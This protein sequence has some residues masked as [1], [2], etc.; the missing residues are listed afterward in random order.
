MIF[1][2]K[3]FESFG[4]ITQKLWQK[5]KWKSRVWQNAINSTGVSCIHPRPPQA[6]ENQQ[7]DANSPFFK[8]WEWGEEGITTSILWV[9][10]TQISSIYHPQQISLQIYWFGNGK[11]AFSIRSPRKFE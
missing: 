7:E 10:L 9:G 8:D 11:K 1:P 3:F 4:A 5:T 2:P 6:K